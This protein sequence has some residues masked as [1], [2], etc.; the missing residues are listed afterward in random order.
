MSE[1]VSIVIVTFNN[2][3]ML[4]NLLSDLRIQLRRPD[5]VFVI[6][7]ASRDNTEKMVRIDYPEAVYV[8]LD[9]NLGSAGG[10]HEGICRASLSSEFIY[11]LDDDV[12]L[13][14][15]TLLEI[16]KGFHALDQSMPGQIAAVRSVGARHSGAAP[17][18]L[19]IVPWRGTLFKTAIVREVGTPSPELFLYGE[20]LEYSLRF[21]QK[22]YK[23][24]WIPS[25][26]CVEASRYSEGKTCSAMFGRQ[27][28]YY[29]EPF[30]LY[31]AFR[32][33][34]FIYIKYRYIFKIFRLLSYAVKV[35]SMLL[36]TERWAGWK[37]FRAVCRGLIDGSMGKLG[38][39]RLYL[40]G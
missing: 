4:A 24:Y 39:N 22:G 35:M 15:Y 7:N 29:R 34:M 18:P 10:Y 25:S 14:P 28:V 3:V 30:R 11:T 40:P 1:R 26:R 17:T 32:N 31:Y 2:A 12:R 5:E 37:M 33:E 13:D 23:C 6:D 27:H 21:K 8:H 9:E 20:D 16:I 19:E 36:V 38:K